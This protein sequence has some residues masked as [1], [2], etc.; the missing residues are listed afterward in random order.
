MSV[1]V[2]LFHCLQKVGGVKQTAMELHNMGGCVDVFV[3]FWWG[4][5]KGEVLV[6]QRGA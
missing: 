5:G 4:A 3:V 2:Y 1:Y 6:K